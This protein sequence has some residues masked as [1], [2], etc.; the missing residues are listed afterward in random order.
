MGGCPAASGRNREGP[1]LT[2]CAQWQ[3]GARDPCRPYG[4]APFQQEGADL[5]DDTG[6]LARMLIEPSVRDDI[7]NSGCGPAGASWSADM[8][9]RVPEQQVG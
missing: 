5:I 9:G 7:D 2:R 8:L 3:L 4:D 1:R 6:T